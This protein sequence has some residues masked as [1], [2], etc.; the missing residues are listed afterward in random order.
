MKVKEEEL[1]TVSTQRRRS[2]EGREPVGCSGS[3]QLGGAS[4]RWPNPWPVQ[5]RS[6][7]TGEI[8]K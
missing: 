5:I 8:P 7:Q 2:I 4:C 1:N 3:L 6:I